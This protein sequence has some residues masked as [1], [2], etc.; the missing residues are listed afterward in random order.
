MWRG[1]CPA[2]CQVFSV[3]LLFREVEGFPYLARWNSYALHI[4]LLTPLSDSLQ[5]TKTLGTP[6]P[7]IFHTIAQ[8][9]LPLQIGS[10]LFLD[11]THKPHS[12]G[13]I[14]HWL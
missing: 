2:L 7:M 3:C 14:E 13:I 12:V 10:G 9:E 4:V 1:L 11:R 8:Q 5:Y 6:P